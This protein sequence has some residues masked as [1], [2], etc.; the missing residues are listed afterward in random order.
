MAPDLDALALLLIERALRV[1][2]QLRLLI[3]TSAALASAAAHAHVPAAA[4][5]D[6][7]WWPF[8]PWVIALLALAAALY[9]VGFARVWRHATTG[10]AVHARHALAFAAAWLVTA[11]ALLG[12]LDALSARLFSAH[13]LQ[14]EALMVVAAPLFVLARPLGAWTWALPQRWR[15]GLGRFFHRRAWRAP[16]L[17]VTAPLGAGLVHGLALWLWH[18]PAWFEAALANDGVHILQHACF[19]IGA[20]LYWWSVLG[21][22]PGRNGGAAMAS[23]FTTMIHTAGLGA[24]LALSPIAWYPTYAGRTIAFG[25]D[26]LEDQQLGGLIMWV[27]AGFAYVACG[28]ATAWHW[29]QRSDRV[30]A[31]A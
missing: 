19:L 23:L 22:R 9:A 15:R 18:I 28:L 31:P 20:L 1:R 27:P 17:V 8:E 25:L 14:H 4:A 30:R 7:D 10:R 3:A 16:W 13:M 21:V 5:A 6:I 29:L 11:A 26:P 12:P 24:L 2:V